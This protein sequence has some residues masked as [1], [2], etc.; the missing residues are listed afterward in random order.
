MISRIW[1][2]MLV[3]AILAVTPFAAMRTDAAESDWVEG[4][5]NRVQLRAGSVGSGEVSVVAFID[6]EMERGWKTYWRNPGEAGGIPPVFDWSKSENVASADV[7]YPAPKRLTDSAGDTVGYKDAVVFPMRLKPTEAAKPMVVRL[8]MA[9][10]ICEKICVPAEANLELEVPATG[11]EAAGVEDNAV[12]DHVPRPADQARPGDPVVTR[13]TQDLAGPKP[14]IM[15]EGRF[16]GN[17]DKADVFLEAQDGLYLPLPRQTSA[18]GDALQYE[19]DLTAD[20]DL[21]TLRG[22]TVRATLVGEHGASEV[23]FKID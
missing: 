16:P 19:A 18:T 21:H 23:T 15:I 2:C 11:L 7:L 17:A 9:Y 13:L 6:L 5:K 10:G 20:V 22:Q 1:L 3:V 4:Y 12:L 8:S 14:H